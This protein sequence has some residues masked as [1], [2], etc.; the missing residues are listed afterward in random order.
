MRIPFLAMLACFAGMLCFSPAAHA[1]KLPINFHGPKGL[2]QKLSG[3]YEGTLQSQSGPVSLLSMQ[4][5]FSSGRPSG[6]IARPG[7]VFSII[8]GNSKHG[9]VTIQFEQNGK[10]GLISANFHG[11]D[12]VGDWNF[13]AEHGTVHLKRELL[14]RPNWM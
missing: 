13:G 4:F 12:L 10:V 2:S 7:D 6:E 3:P 14:R 9:H 1:S 5:N 11:S 8:G